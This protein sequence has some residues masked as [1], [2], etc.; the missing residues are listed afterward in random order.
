MISENLL[1][2][3]QKPVWDS[4]IEMRKE[5]RQGEIDD[6]SLWN[7]LID[8][9][10]S[11]DSLPSSQK[12]II[13]Q[14]QATVLQIAGY[15]ILSAINAAQAIKTA[16]N[17]FDSELNRSWTIL[18]EVTV[19]EPIQNLLESVAESLMKQS[20]LPEGFGSDWMY[21][22]GNAFAKSNQN[23]LANNAYAQVKVTDRYFFPAKYQQAML[24][25]DAGQYDKA[26]TSLKAILFPTSQD[27]SSLSR[28]ERSLISGDAN[29]ALARIYYE[30]K[31]FDLSMKHYRRVSRESSSFYD[32]LFEQSW[33][34]FMAGYP[35][36]ALGML[37]SV[38]SPF[39][40]EAF[41]PEAT[42]LASIIY[43]WM[44]RYNDSRNELADF[45]ENHQGPIK[46]LN[47]YLSR[48]NISDQSAY[49]LFENTVTG[50]S[51][52]GLGMPRSLLMSAAQQDS[53]MH[54]R[55]Q[56][57]S[58]LSELQRLEIKGIFGEKDKISTPRGYLVNWAEDLKGDIG[59]KF[60]FE[61]RDLK[62]EFERLN[63]QAQFLYVELLMSQKDQLLGKELHSETKFNS[64]V[65]KENI[66]GWG[67]KT[68][69]WATDDKLEYWQDE[70]GY[71]IFRQPPLCNTK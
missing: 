32:S 11:L 65:S 2:Q 67:K 40:K 39:F 13:L 34:L 53:L 25:L 64:V 10:A 41:N 63:D 18:K 59:R 46:T 71:H 20:K 14:T 24:S 58:V 26:I 45:I 23:N 22:Q 49:T 68:Q 1:A 48:Q 51:S 29:L 15:P 19:A 30:Q 33:A 27:L 66:A 36:H 4:F 44:C 35:N 57:A 38:R 52:E 3:A 37:F 54:V 31:K 50:V 7:K 61:L 17:P 55:D 21:F 16:P 69:V 60:I 5:Y 28:Q 8:I 43:Y 12:S 47:E 70:L 9:S 6:A 42:M 56:Y 62:K